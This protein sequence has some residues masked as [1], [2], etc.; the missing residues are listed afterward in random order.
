MFTRTEEGMKCLNLDSIPIVLLILLPTV[1]I[2]FLQERFSS[3]KTRR[4]F[5]QSFRSSFTLYRWF[6]QW[7][8][9]IVKSKL[10]GFCLAAL[11]K[12]CKSSYSSLR[13]YKLFSISG[14]ERP[15]SC[16]VLS[17]DCFFSRSFYRPLKSLVR[18]SGLLFRP[19]FSLFKDLNLVIIDVICTIVIV[20]FRCFVLLRFNN[21]VNFFIPS[22]R[23]NISH[24]KWN[25]LITARFPR[26]IRLLI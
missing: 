21:Y 12:F 8:D 10:R 16:P 18:A 9:Q 26:I 24:M 25:C 23:W 3:F 15:P 19:S 20:R 7:R 6:S 5:M 2:C 11:C 22:L 17:V 14:N 13:N 1:T 4:Y